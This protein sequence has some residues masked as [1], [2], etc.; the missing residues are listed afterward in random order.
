MQTVKSIGELKKS[1]DKAV[2][3]PK[4]EQDIVKRLTEKTNDDELKGYISRLY[5][6]VFSMSK[7]YLV[8]LEQR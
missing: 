2:Y 7:A 1:E 3:A 4:R 6:D 8:R 5:A